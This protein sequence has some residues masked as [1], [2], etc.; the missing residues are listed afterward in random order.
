[1]YI[2]T[3]NIE[4]MDIIHNVQHFFKTTND[5]SIFQSL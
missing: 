2:Y 1:M 3:L 4:K 5:H